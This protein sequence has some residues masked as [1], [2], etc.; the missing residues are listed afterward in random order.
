MRERERERE[1]E[2][3]VCGDKDAMACVLLSYF[4]FI[5]SVKKCKSCKSLY[6]YKFESFFLLR[7]I[8]FARKSKSKMLIA[9][10]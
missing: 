10:T 3:A 5:M 4:D 8:L 7:F 2:R 1:R 6:F 9:T